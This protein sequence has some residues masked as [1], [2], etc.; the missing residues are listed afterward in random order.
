MNILTLA[1]GV[2]IVLEFLNIM[3]L[4]FMP[5][6]TRGNGIGVFTAWEK[7]KEIP[8][9]HELVKYLTYWVAGTKLIFVGLII[10]VIFT[11]SYLAQT[12]AVVVLILSIASFYWR[13]YP[14]MKSMDGKGWISPKGYS[15]TLG[16]MIA[17]FIGVFII[18][19]VIG[20]IS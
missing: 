17:V 15:K 1:M 6:S 4:Y 16:I 13:L 20:L 10:V 3:T 12:F 11:G 2:F 18:A 7:S 14:M 9:V 8:E 5:E 19:L